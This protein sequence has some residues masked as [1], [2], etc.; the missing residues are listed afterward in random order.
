M[1]RQSKFDA[2]NRTLKAGARGQRRGMGWEGVGG[3]SGRG[4]TYTR[5]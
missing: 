3:R 4:L 2:W 1:K 5:G